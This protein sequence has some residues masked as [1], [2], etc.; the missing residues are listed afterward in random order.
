MVVAA[1]TLGG[2]TLLMVFMDDDVFG[3]VTVGGGLI[4][5]ATGKI[6][7]AGAFVDAEA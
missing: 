3:T 4:T 1:P 6:T 2:R 7:S 5:G